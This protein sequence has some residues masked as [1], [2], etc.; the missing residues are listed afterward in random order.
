[1]SYKISIK[2]RNDKGVALLIVAASLV[3]ILGMCALG[4][5]LVAAYLARVQ[6]QRAADSAALAGAKAFVASGCTSTGGCVAGG[7]QEASATVNANSAAAQNHVMGLAPTA[8]TISVAFSYPDPSEPEITVTVYRDSTHTDALPT[9]FAKIFGI[10]S[11]NI[12]ATAT[13]EAYN[14]QIGA[15]CI[16]PF[17]VPNCNPNHP[18]KVGDSRANANCPCG[19]GGVTQGDC[20][21]GI[22]YSSTN[23][24]VMAYYVYPVGSANQGQIVDPGVCT[25]DGTRCTSGVVGGPWVLHNNLN[26]TVPSQWYTIAFT[27]QSGQAYSNY[28]AQCAPEYVACGS[29]L[30]T[31]NGKKVGP[32]NQGI[33]DL[34][35]ASGQG[36]N[37]G[38]DYMCSP[39]YG[40]P[41]YPSTSYCT[42]LPFLISG[43]ANNLYNPGK[44]FDL[45]TGTSDS[46]VNVV[47]Y[48]GM[49][50]SPGG[51]TVVVQGYMSLFI[52]AVDH[53]S[54]QDNVY[55]VVTQVGACGGGPTGPTSGNIA[56]SGGGSFI[57]I[58]L[59]RTN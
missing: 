53:T 42:S 34:I 22:S 48:D 41:Q 10:N 52:Q 39:S 32:T 16:K 29:S 8:S 15:G 11:M 14:G 40:G 59:I 47:L 1:M 3:I 9:M 18:V 26:A 5:D 36:Y 44:T 46:Q 25:W 23:P 6:C 38:Q 55:S 30:D 12:S 19:G 4:I 33:Q 28:I 2:H 51:S 37:K 20:P 21:A 27:T 17:L 49:P 43:G 58:R 54:T 7:P 57:P 50:L 13:A 31:L 35:H 24:W 56:T 45:G